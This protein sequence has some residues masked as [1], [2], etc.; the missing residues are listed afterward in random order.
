M[1][2][3]TPT[4]PVTLVW[5]NQQGLIFRRTISVDDRYMFKVTDS[6]ENTDRGRRYPVSLRQAAPRGYA[7]S[8]RFLHL[9]RGSDRCAR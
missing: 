5:D 9:A 8:A 4:N 1:V 2:R 7:G 6:V 3:S